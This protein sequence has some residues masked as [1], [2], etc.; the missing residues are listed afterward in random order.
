[1]LRHKQ[2][3]VESAR[4]GEGAEVFSPAAQLAAVSWPSGPE[5]FSSHEFG[6]EN[7]S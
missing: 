3:M 4:I 1:M 6:I 5:Q 2:E 7:P